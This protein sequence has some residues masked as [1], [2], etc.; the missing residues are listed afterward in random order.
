[1]YVAIVFFNLLGC[2]LSKGLSWFNNISFIIA[3]K[4]NFLGINLVLLRFVVDFLQ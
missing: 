3:Q 1:M 4:G 2:L